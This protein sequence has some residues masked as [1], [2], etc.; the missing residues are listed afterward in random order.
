MEPLGEERDASGV[1][2]HAG[3]PNP[4]ADRGGNAPLSLDRLLIKH[5]VSTYFF[6]IR[7]HSWHRY[8]VFDGDLAI[9]DRALN[10]RDNELVVWWDEAGAFHL[11]DR[12]TADPSN[13]WGTL[14]A[15]VHSFGMQND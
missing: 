3:F 4:A 7:G 1:A 10:P 2:V 11:S 8:G 13:L 14:T 9:I 15:V 12:K 5:P 6:R